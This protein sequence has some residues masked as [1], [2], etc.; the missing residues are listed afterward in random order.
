[1]HGGGVWRE[2]ERKG[3]GGG[4]AKEEMEGRMVRLEVTISHS[5]GGNSTSSY[6]Q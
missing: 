2:G 5:L 6:V 3:L 1:M 4:G